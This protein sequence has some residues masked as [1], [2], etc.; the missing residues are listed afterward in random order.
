MSTVTEP[1]QTIEMR[2]KEAE[3]VGVDLEWR[4]PP[5]PSHINHNGIIGSRKRTW[6]DA[7]TP[8]RESIDQNWDQDPELVFLPDLDSG[9]VPAAF[10]LTP[11]ISSQHGDSSH[12]VAN[13]DHVEEIPRTKMQTGCIPCL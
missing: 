2:D 13:G 1:L 5:R 10:D 8:V 9:L 11:A 7:K 4:T 3:W 6:E 12:L